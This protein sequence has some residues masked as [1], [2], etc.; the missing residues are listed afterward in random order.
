MT[1]RTI[2]PRSR[3]QTAAT[4][5]KT[6]L[7]AT[8]D[9][10]LAKQPLMPEISESNRI[11][12]R[13]VVE[14]FGKRPKIT[15]YWDDDHRY[16]VDLAAVPDSPQEWITSYSTVNLSDWPMFVDGREHQTRVE[17]AA[18]APSEVEGF[19]NAVSTAAFFVIRSKRSCEPGAIFPDV[20]SMYQ[21]SK[22]M[23]HVLITE[24]FLWDGFAESLELADRLVTW[25]MMVPISDSEYE[26]AKAKGSQALD[27]LLGE[28]EIDAYDLERK[29][30][31]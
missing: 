24:P 5:G 31:V 14:V 15:T 1:R 13:K 29:P 28:R 27:K 23:Q 2:D 3:A 19:G 22:T 7:V 4:P 6:R 8:W 12:A 30:V 10:K 25:V 17:I 9:P 16:S 11:V 21:L 18:A 20:L 26:Y